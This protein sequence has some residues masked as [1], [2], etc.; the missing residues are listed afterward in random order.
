MADKPAQKNKNRRHNNKNRSKNNKNRYYRGK[1]GNRKHSSRNSRTSQLTSINAIFKKYDNLLEN[2]L[3]LRAKYFDYFF[4]AASK[5]KSKVTENYRNALAQLRKFEQQLTDYQKEKFQQRGY[6]KPDHTYCENH[7]LD[8]DLTSV[9]LDESPIDPHICTIQKER[10]SYQDD[11]QESIGTM[12]D[13]KAYKGL[14]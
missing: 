12:D 13:Y 10:P 2:Y 8:P 14:Q 5:Q 6:F 3:R 9:E 11:N 4:R 7:N 1:G